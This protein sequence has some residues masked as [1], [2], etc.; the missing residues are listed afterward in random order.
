MLDAMGTFSRRRSPRL[1]LAGV[2]ACLL[3][4]GCAGAK[5]TDRMETRTPQQAAADFLFGQ[6]QTLL[7]Q[8]QDGFVLAPATGDGHPLDAVGQD[9]IDV[10]QQ[11]VGHGSPPWLGARLPRIGRGAKGPARAGRH[12]RPARPGVPA[13]LAWAGSG[14][15]SRIRRHSQA[16]SNRVGTTV[17]ALSAKKL[18]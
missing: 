17:I 16:S 6:E 10:A 7:E 3:S 5:D 2:L 4:A 8:A 18:R 12:A 14:S 1:C 13:Q 11:Q 15:R 9:R